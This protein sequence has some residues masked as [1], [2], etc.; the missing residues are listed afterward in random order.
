MIIFNIKSLLHKKSF[1]EN[2]KL[3][4]KDIEKETG[5]KY[6]QLSR[7]NSIPNY[8]ASIIN[9]ELLCN[10][11]NCTPNDLISIHKIQPKDLL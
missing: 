2:K 1:S 9:I 6:I 11:F 5:I 10:Y 7:M 4:F 3:T 8:N